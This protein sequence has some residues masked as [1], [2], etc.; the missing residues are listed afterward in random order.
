MIN[1]TIHQANAVTEQETGKLLEYRHLIKGPDREIWKKAFANDLGRLAQGVGKRMTHGTNTVFFVHPSTIPRH[2]KV[3]YE[4][5]VADLRPLKEETHRVRVTLGGDRLPY[6]GPTATH[7][8]SLVLV[9]THLN[10]VVST[11]GAKYATLGIKDYFY[12]TPMT[13]YE[14][15][16]LPMETIPQ[17]I[18]QQYNLERKEKD[19][20]VYMEVRKGMPGL[21]QGGRIAH[22]RLVKHL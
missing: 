8:A 22:D 15:V 14:Y 13:T 6:E 21:N 17:E 1:I 11:P 19:G 2:K 4:K 5:L 16:R 12:G 3:T 10:S 18:I 20:S 9:K 7:S